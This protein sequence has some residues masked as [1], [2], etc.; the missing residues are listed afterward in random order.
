[1]NPRLLCLGVF[2]ASTIVTPAAER[3]DV[4]YDESKVGTYTLCYVDH[5]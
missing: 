4:N 3:R 2:A 1:M 5:T